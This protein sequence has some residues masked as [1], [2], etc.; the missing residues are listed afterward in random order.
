MGITFVK[1]EVNNTKAAAPII[2]GE[3]DDSL[4]LGVFSLKALGLFLILLSESCGR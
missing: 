1:A 3:K 2:F 4:L